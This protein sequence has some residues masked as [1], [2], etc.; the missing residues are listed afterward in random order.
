MSHKLLAQLA[1]VDAS[2][3]AMV[4]AKAR[5]ESAID[6]LELAK[7]WPYGDIYIDGLELA[8]VWPYG[9]GYSYGTG[10]GTGYGYGDGAGDGNGG[11]DG[12]DDDD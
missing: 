8:K 9:D 4:E 12:S 3:T 11:G 2:T 10:Y 7:V 6:G 1:E 5:L